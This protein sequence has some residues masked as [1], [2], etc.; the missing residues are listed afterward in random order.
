MS[1]HDPDAALERLVVSGLFGPGTDFDRFAWR[2]FHEGVEIARLYGGGDGGPAAA[3]LRYAP[4]ARVPH[5]LHRGNEHIL[6]LRGSQRDERGTYDAGT[7]L[8]HGV[9]TGHSVASDGGCI[10]LAIWFAPVEIAG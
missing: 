5:H 2:P 7:L 4:G 10:V 9:G 3:L 8:A 1:A 6:V